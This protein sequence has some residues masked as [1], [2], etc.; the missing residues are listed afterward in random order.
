MAG[1]LISLRPG[2]D[3][4]ERVRSH[5]NVSLLSRRCKIC[6]TAG[7]QIASAADLYDCP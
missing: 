2:V 3:V 4:I 7:T 5:S 6:F 1:I